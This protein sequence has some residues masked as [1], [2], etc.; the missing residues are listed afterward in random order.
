MHENKSVDES[1]WSDLKQKVK[2]MDLNEPPELDAVDTLQQEE[3][4]L[5]E[6]RGAPSSVSIYAT[7]SKGH[8]EETEEPSSCRSNYSNLTK[9]HHKEATEASSHGGDDATDLGVHGTESASDQG[10]VVRCRLSD[11]TMSYF[12]LGRALNKHPQ[13][14]SVMWLEWWKCQELL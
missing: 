14:M 3:L 11:R 8:G 1:A 10:T 2:A 4:Q 5:K 13:W 12:N 9:T 6:N 7:C